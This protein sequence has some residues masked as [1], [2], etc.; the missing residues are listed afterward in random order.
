ML[1]VQ[2]LLSGLG[3]KIHCPLGQP[4]GLVQQLQFILCWHVIYIAIR[5]ALLSTEDVMSIW[6]QLHI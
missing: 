1:A 5:I 2:F 4:Q 3:S 6:M